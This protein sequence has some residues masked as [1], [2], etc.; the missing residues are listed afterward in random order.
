MSEIASGGGSTGGSGD[1][2]GPPDYDPPAAGSDQDSGPVPA[3]PP[4]GF[5]QIIV[6]ESAT[7][8]AVMSQ[9]A[10]VTPN[11]IRRSTS[12]KAPPF[13]LEAEQS[14]LGGLML[15]NNAWFNVAEVVS[16]TDFYRGQH[17]I[18]FEAITDLA[19]DNQPLDA[20][21]LS[22]RL[23]SKGLLD[24]AGGPGYLAELAES[25]PGASNIVA[26]S[27]IVRE[28]STIRQLIGAAN[29][30]AESAF[31]R[32]GR[33]SDV[34]LDLA[35]QEVFRIAEG[36]LK[37]GGPQGVRPLLDSAVKRIDELY[38]SRG[39][40]TGLATGFD[41]LDTK[42]SGLQPSDLIIVAGRPSMGKTS[43]ALNIVEHAAMEGDGVVLVFSMEMSAEQLVMRMLSSLGRIDQTRM[44]NGDLKE[45]DWP[46]F[47]S[48]VAQLR[49]KA[50]F[51]DDT[52]AL[53]PIELRTRARR[54]AREAGNLGLIVVDYIQLMRGSLD[55]EN[56]TTEISEIS[57]SLK[58]IAK[59]MRCPV[60]AISQ[61]NRALEIRA[62]K[63]PVM[64]DLRD[65]GAIEQDADVILFI[66]RDEVY[67]PESPDAGTA[68]IIIGKQRNG[69]IGR[70]R[71]S[72]IGNLTKFENL[73][74]DRH[75]DYSA[76]D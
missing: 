53:T 59:E 57:R 25:T 28:H 62:D 30:I 36:R 44:R 29:R 19:T 64:S 66:Y 35:E 18:I 56:R 10:G 15:D 1:G 43:L 50:L 76:F 32:D 22:E 46:R 65:S 38:K 7:R 9:P 61:L 8:D 11:L 14:V 27:Q 68:E 39:S 73:A 45:D 49:D 72:F 52:P 21:T 54:V 55:Y 31:A 51:I 69:P 37:E 70:V 40:I 5:E 23:Q 2:E 33:T 41:E 6:P 12:P 58:A 75:A 60:V 63:R 48:A 24:K 42:T 4:A 26:Y 74:P 13:S 34:L 20:V 3:G 67:N 71:L 47:T 17:Q 16:S